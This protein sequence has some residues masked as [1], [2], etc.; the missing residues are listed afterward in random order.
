M[1]ASRGRVNVEGKISGQSSEAIAEVTLVAKIS[2]VA[3]KLMRK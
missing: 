2:L 3:C 1:Y